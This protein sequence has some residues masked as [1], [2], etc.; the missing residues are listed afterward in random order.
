MSRLSEQPQAE[1]NLPAKSD[2]DLIIAAAAQDLSFPKMLKFTKAG[3]YVSGGQLVPMG[4]EMIAHCVAFTKEWIKF[5]D[6]IPAERRTY[7][8]LDGI[9]PPARDH[10]PD[11]DW[12]NNPKLKMDPWS[13]NYMVPMEYLQGGEQVVFVG[14][15]Q[16][17]RRAVSDLC[18]AWARKRQKDRSVGLPIIKLSG[19]SF[20][21]NNWGEVKRPYFEIIGWEGGDRESIREF[22]TA[23]LREDIRK[24]MGGDDIPF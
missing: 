12:Q 24:D 19:T 20:H 14:P 11:N 4:T 7:R 18:T 6:G 5:V 15:S 22:T 21:S 2:E 16:G 9:D 8:A 1:Y 17:A 3:E 10:M 23:E 13:L